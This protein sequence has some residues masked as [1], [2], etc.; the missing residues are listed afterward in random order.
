MGWDLVT[1]MLVLYTCIM[2]PFNICFDADFTRTLQYDITEAIIDGIFFIDVIVNFN[3]AYMDVDLNEYVWVRRKIAKKYMKFWF[4]IDFLSCIPLE[5]IVRPFDRRLANRLS[6]IK[7]IKLLRLNRLGS[8]SRNLENVNFKPS[9]ISLIMLFLS[10]FYVVHIFACIWYWVTTGA[11]GDVPRVSWVTLGGYSAENQIELYIAAYY[12]ATVTMLSIGYGDIRGTSEIEYATA[13]VIVLFGSIVFGALISKVTKVLANQNPRKR[14][15]KEMMDEMKN[16]LEAKAIPWPLV[17]EAEEAYRYYLV[18]TTFFK[19]REV[20]PELPRPIMNRLIFHVY[21]HEIKMV[22]MFHQ[23]TSG[24][25]ADLLM[26]LRP[27]CA[28]HGAI[29]KNFNGEYGMREWEGWQCMR[30]WEGWLC[31][32]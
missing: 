13:I 9:T 12:F 24:F 21:G 27:F 15:V 3:T 2:I 5:Q 7:I 23:H 16:S 26:Y 17:K 1:S 10:I 6:F 4:W 14:F 32:N 31:I 20:L 28:K 30:E 8:L 18:H 19:E 22:K 29:V 25:S 11:I